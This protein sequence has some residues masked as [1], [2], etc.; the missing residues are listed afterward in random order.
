MLDLH[1]GAT[2]V[3]EYLGMW[4]NTANRSMNGSAYHSDKG[5]SKVIQSCALL[6]LSLVLLPSENTEVKHIT[7]P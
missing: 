5:L 7:S 3:P 2:Y 4:P 6:A 1:P